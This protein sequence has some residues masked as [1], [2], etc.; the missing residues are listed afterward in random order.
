MWRTTQQ[1]SKQIPWGQIAD[2]SL[3]VKNDM[4]HTQAPGCIQEP[5]F[6]GPNGGG[7]C[8]ESLRQWSVRVL[9]TVVSVITLRRQR[10]QDDRRCWQLDF[11]LVLDNLWENVHLNLEQVKCTTAGS[12]IGRH[13][14]LKEK[15]SHII[16][17]F[18]FCCCCL[19]YLVETRT[20][21]QPFPSLPVSRGANYFWDLLT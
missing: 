15:Q 2:L 11:D 9:I 4:L 12:D 10:L 1:A 5:M 7:L 19:V 14:W 13:V 21:N 17:P 6:P 3:L 16:T 8:V 18:F 20:T